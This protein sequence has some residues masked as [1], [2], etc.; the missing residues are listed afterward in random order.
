MLTGSTHYQVF[1]SSSSSFP[2]GGDRVSITILPSVVVSVPF[3]QTEYV[4]VRACN[5]NGCGPY[6]NTLTITN[7]INCL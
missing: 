5:G 7:D 4:R 1:K 6:S 2:D 3:N